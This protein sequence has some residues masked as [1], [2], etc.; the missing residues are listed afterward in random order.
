ME[1]TLEIAENEIINIPEEEYT[2]YEK[3][4]IETLK[5]YYNEIVGLNNNID[6]QLFTYPDE[7]NGTKLNGRGE[8]NC[9]FINR[10]VVNSDLLEVVNVFFHNVTHARTHA[11]D[12]SHAFRDFL[13][14][15]LGKQALK[16]IKIDK[17][18]FDKMKQEGVLNEEEINAISSIIEE[19]QENEAKHI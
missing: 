8:N 18:I 12:E 14:Y 2:P 7:Y 16:M 6:I 1:T 10:D 17:V 4:I 11:N 9:V 15:L 5:K 13:T 3:F 19:N